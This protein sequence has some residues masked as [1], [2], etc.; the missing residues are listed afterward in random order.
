LQIIY[1]ELG[2]GRQEW[3]SENAA[4]FDASGA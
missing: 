1:S 2:R 3:R 4:L